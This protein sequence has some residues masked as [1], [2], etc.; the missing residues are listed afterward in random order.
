MS[1]FKKRF[2]QHLESL[3]PGQKTA[4]DL[5]DA[6]FGANQGNAEDYEHILKYAEAIG[7]DFK[8]ELSD[9]CA[10]WEAAKKTTA[11]GRAREKLQ[12]AAG[13]IETSAAALKTESDPEK[14]D[15]LKNTI[16]LARSKIETSKP[17]SLIIPFDAYIENLI[18]RNWWEDFSPDLF[19]RLPFKDGT[20]SAIGA[21]PGGGKTAGLVNIVRELITMP[22]VDDP[23][24]HKAQAKN[25]KRKILFY[26]PK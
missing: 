19:N 2:Y 4:Q 25:K 5:R 8:N 7:I 12:A 1:E 6:A 14:I 23:I 22:E 21:A 9:I 3:P 11:E 20:M 26:P 17:K 18:N 16:D 13:E 10:K 15:A 24:Y